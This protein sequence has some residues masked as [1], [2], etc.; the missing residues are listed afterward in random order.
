[1]STYMEELSAL[2]GILTSGLCTCCSPLLEH[3]SPDY[4]YLTPFRSF[5]K[6]QLLSMAFPYH[7]VKTTTSPS[8]IPYPPV[9]PSL[10]SCPLTTPDTQYV[11]VR[12]LFAPCRSP[13]WMI[14][15]MR[16]SIFACITH[17]CILHPWKSAWHVVGVQEV[18]V[19]WMHE[20]MN[21]YWLQL[22]RWGLWIQLRPTS[23]PPPPLLSLQTDW[24]WFPKRPMNLP[25]QVSPRPWKL[26]FPLLDSNPGLQTQ[27]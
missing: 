13:H 26:I 18:F 11:H 8:S 6:Y 16:T 24:T 4:P 7:A 21:D 9:L 17:C 19:E 12:I 3:P 2:A 22:C 14:S 5:L 1:M 23:N 25:S 10:S 20:W 27:E 15:S